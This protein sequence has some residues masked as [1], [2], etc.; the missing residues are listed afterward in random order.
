MKKRKRGRPHASQ[1][2]VGR[3]GILSSARTLLEKLPPH[4][5]TI[6][7]IARQAGV[8]PALVRYYFSSREDLLIAVIENI[9]STWTATHTPAPG[10]TPWS[11]SQARFVR[12][13]G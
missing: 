11:T 4:Q 3:E 6:V 2:P 9:V 12:C 5:V 7:K 1:Q 8:D 13:N 10:E